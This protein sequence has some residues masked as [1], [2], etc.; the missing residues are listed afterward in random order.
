M[1]ARSAWCSPPAPS[2][3]GG[4][5]KPSPARETVVISY[6]PNVRASVTPDGRG[7][8]VIAGRMAALA[9]I[10]KMSD[11]DLAFLFPGT[12]PEQFA[13]RLLG[14]K[15]GVTQLLVVTQG[16]RGAV[17]ATRNSSFSAAAIPVAVV[18]TVGAGDAFMAALLAGSPMST[19]YQRKRWRSAQRPVGTCCT[20]SP[21]RQW[22]PR[23]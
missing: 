21:I 13:T 6:D 2:R 19:W 4:R 16:P 10:V 3:C 1:S 14:P 7:S 20:E 5:R 12:T 11:E 22:P 23:R 15:A 17:A 8:A 9:H 18:D